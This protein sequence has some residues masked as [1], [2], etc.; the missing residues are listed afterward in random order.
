VKI[1][2]PTRE[3]WFDSVWPESKEGDERVLVAA[4]E[5][6]K[7]GE[8]LLASEVK[9]GVIFM[10]VVEDFDY[11]IAALPSLWR[12]PHAQGGGF[13]PNVWVGAAF[14]TQKQL[15]DRATRL[16][17][18]KARRLFLM[19]KRDHEPFECFKYLEPWRCMNCG[20]RGFTEWPL[21]CPT[22]AICQDEDKIM[23]Q[24]SWLVDMER[25]EDLRLD[26]VCEGMRVAL[27]DG[28]KKEVP[29]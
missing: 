16:L 24:I 1:N 12:R 4:H 10:F 7:L 3:H 2:F 9:K 18:I 6:G 14:S 5:G 21:Y 11:F 15:D 23:P 20:R 13:P 28:A 27:W 25:D 22:G 29:E 26:E 19:A 8:A 17:K